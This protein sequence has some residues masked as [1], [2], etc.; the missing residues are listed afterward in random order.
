MP[1]AV[2]RASR[3]DRFGTPP[4]EMLIETRRP[5]TGR[6]PSAADGSEVNAGIRCLVRCHRYLRREQP[7]RDHV[8]GGPVHRV[9]GD[10]PIVSEVE[11]RK[12]LLPDVPPGDGPIVVL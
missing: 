8:V 2:T 6:R 11:D 4:G 10:Q 5:G 9:D 3:T 7:S 12:F 1:L